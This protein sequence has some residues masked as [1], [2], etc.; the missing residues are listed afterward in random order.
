MRPD[1]PPLTRH[2]LPMSVLFARQPI[3]DRSGQVIAYEL[4]YRSPDHLSHAAGTAVETMASTVIVD[5]VLSMG[6]EQAVDGRIAF[7]NMPRPHLVGGVVELLDPAGVVV[8][9]LE[10]IAPDAE[11]VGACQRLR[12]HGYRLALDDYVAGD[13][14][15][16]LLGHV[17]LV[18]VDVMSTDAG[19]LDSLVREL[20][21]RPTQLVAEKVEDEA[22]RDRCVRL[23][24]ELFQ[25]Y[26]FRKPELIQGHDLSP[27]VVRALALMNLLRDPAVPQ[28]EIVEGF[29][30][31]PGLTY[32]LLRMANSAAVGA[33][34][35]SSI[36]H[37]IGL[38][39]RGPL[40]RWVALIFAAGAGR[41]GGTKGELLRE[42]MIRARFCEL[43]AEQAAARA[44]SGEA[45]IVGLFSCLEPLLGVPLLTVLEKVRLAAEAR[46][47]LTT[48]SG[49]LAW[50]LQL[51]ETYEAGDWDR[52]ALIAAAAGVGAEATSRTYV[53]A[54]GW[55][56]ACLAELEG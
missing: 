18:K 52:V 43:I 30:V 34:A 9:I 24:F 27:D 6:L 2:N 17:D 42:A 35:V 40:Y 48:R 29:R 33:R 55:M 16:G 56:R 53:E 49:P 28:A 19:A 36:P 41:A 1:R 50:V 7:L 15:E 4:L 3:F 5:A 13:P 32:K 46:A 31:D 10:D 21:G 20:R 51:S 54:L 45:F 47:A 37:A 38:L 39:G 22:M 44:D 8:E 12:A 14:R 11:V 26:F 23:G 25:G